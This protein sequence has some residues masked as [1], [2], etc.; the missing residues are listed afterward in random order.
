MCNKMQCNT[1]HY[2]YTKMLLYFITISYDMILNQEYHI[3]YK[4]SWYSNAIMYMNNSCNMYLL[5]SYV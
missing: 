2:I 3:M 5:K 4:I 1:R